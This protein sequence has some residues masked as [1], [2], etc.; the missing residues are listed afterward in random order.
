MKI[1][2]VALLGALTVLW[3]GWMNSPESGKASEPMLEGT[4]F[5]QIAPQIG[6]VPM[7]LEFGSDKCMSCQQMG[8]LLYKIK[9]KHPEAMIYFVDIYQDMP[10]ARKFGIR[11]IPT[12]KFLDKE[13]QVI[14]THIGV[15]E[16][17]TVEKKL[18]EMGVL[19]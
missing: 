10:A 16:Q 6:K 7:M 11:M 18:Q 8:R 19:K 9:Q 13:G 4:S 14:D 2:I 12:Q 1:L 17:E 15:L 5:S 3:A